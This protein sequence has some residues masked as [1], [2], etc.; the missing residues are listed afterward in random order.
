MTG[1]ESV[2][3]EAE[4]AL[5]WRRRWFSEGGRDV[6]LTRFVLLRGVGFI[7]LVAFGILVQ[8]GLPLLGSRGLMPV[9][10]FLARVSEQ[11][12]SWTSAVWNVP[13]LFW[14]SCSDGW[15]LGLAWLGLLLGLA[16]TLGLANAPLLFCSWVLYES[17]VHV[18]QTFYGYGWDMLLLETGFLAIFLAP[19]WQPWPRSRAAPALP[20]IWLF[21]WLLF[22]LMLGAG[23]IKLRGDSCWTDLTC[24]VYHY[25]TQP[26]PHPLSWLLHQAP[27]WF[28]AG[29]VL[30]NHAVELLA[31]FGLF[32]PRRVRHVAGA[33]TAAFQVMLILSGNLAFLNWLT[34]VIAC[35]CFDD[36]L[37]ARVLPGRL[38]RALVVP[39]S[40][41]L[42]RAR[43]AVTVGLCALVA[44]LSL[45]PIANLASS[46]QRM[47]SGYDP[48]ELVNT[49]GAFGSVSR[50]RHEVVIEGARAAQPGSEPEWLEYQFP[51]KPGDTARAPCWVT[52]YHYR[53]DWQMW[54]AG[55]SRA[56]REPWILHLAYEL[57]QGDPG[58]LGLLRSNPFPD[59][60]PAL[61][62]A[63]LYRYAFTG[64]GERG[65]WRRERVG[66]YLPVLSLDDPR[67]RDFLERYGWL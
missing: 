26:N 44:V 27:P 1:S 24:L 33:L 19:A 61:V 39:D 53:L 29:G 67:L 14:L 36:S 59:A 25:E 45:N 8:Q 57:L 56:E 58:V 15:L 63:S 34:L 9:R 46:R 3:L 48:L 62:R 43:R 49:Y 64:W 11:T 22:R 2:R 38:T 65:W 12:P 18:G 20:V 35:A 42:S 10:V 16:I 41:P 32:G 66:A 23:L 50:V 4:P 7:Y 6:Q 28:H 47:N 60:P 5:H 37:L 30:V 54:F 17:F 13:S 55:L 51:C 40:L 31:P 21:R 52:P